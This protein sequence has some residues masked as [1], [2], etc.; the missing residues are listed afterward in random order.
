MIAT[1]DPVAARLEFAVRAARAASQSTLHY[2][3]RDDLQVDRKGDASPVTVADREAEQL[4]RGEIARAF[5]DDA[6]LGEEFGETPGTSGY[7]WILDPI[8]GT[9]AFIHGVPLYGTLVGVEHAGASLIG[10]IDIPALEERAWAAIGH[11]AWYTMGAS[12][13]RP[14]RVSRRSRLADGLLV[15]SQVDSFASTRRAAAFERLQAAAS[16]T[17]TWGDCYGYLLVA[18]GRAEAM[19]DP[20]MNVWDAAALLPILQEAGGTFT[21][22][23]GAAT[24]HSGEGIATNALVLAEVLDCCRATS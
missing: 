23:R 19:V 16:V 6:I 3:R 24:I 17:R 22:W 7:R 21:D 9:K 10:V 1:C 2:F 11:G 13:P 15:T 18:T 5:P 20:V 12:E 8:D 4:L 14:A